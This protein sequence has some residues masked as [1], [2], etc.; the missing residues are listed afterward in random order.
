M[1]TML[2]K[3]FKTIIPNGGERCSFTM[4]QRNK[5]NKT[6]PRTRDTVDGSEIRRAPVEVGSL[7]EFFYRVSYMSGGVRRISEASTVS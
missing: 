1:A 5:S 2:G 3:S 7:S 6:H 4:V